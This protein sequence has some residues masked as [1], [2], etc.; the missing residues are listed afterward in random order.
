MTRA[1][2][3]AVLKRV[4]DSWRAGD[5]AAAA[6]CFAED[7]E[8]LDP[9][10][11]RFT[12]RADL[13]PFFEPPT[14]G[15]HVTWHSILW[16][17]EAQTGVVEYTYE[18]DH[19]YHGAAIVRLDA[20]GRIA[21]WREWQHQD[22]ELDWDSRLRGPREGGVIT[23]IDHVQL[24]MPAGGEDAARTFYADALGLDEIR[25]PRQLAGRG[26]AWFAS[27][28]VAVHL[29]VDVDFR[30]CNARGGG[31]GGGGRGP[32]EGRRVV[33]PLGCTRGERGARDWRGERPAARRPY[34][35]KIWLSRYGVDVSSWSYRHA[36]GDLSGRQR[37]NVVP[38]RNRSP[39]RWS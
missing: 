10:R 22:D 39:W 25:K 20:D 7:V 36:A 29:G 8:Y 28:T 17:D 16:D 3:L 34:D 21:L 14:G 23:A 30:S 9:Y 38:W 11:F 19:R 6:D 24:S 5:A 26:G 12:R 37:L 31:R 32:G 2:F 1:L 13:L 18:G 4:A 33:P 27:G 15:H 35:P